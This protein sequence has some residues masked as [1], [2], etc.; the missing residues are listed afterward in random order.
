MNV[1]TRFEDYKLTESQQNDS[2]IRIA[3]GTAA[4]G[5]ER[6]KAGLS[7]GGMKKRPHTDTTVPYI[8]AD[9]QDIMAAL[10]RTPPPPD[11]LGKPKQAR[12]P[13]SKAGRKR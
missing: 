2:E 3:A 5:K 6:R 7:Q 13:R 12:K 8:P 10:L 11:D 4:M 9:P 1:M